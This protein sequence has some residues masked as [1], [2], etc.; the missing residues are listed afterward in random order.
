MP[1]F[2]KPSASLRNQDTESHEFEGGNTRLLT[3]AVTKAKCEA[4]DISILL[5]S[6]R[7]W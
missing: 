7:D 4:M 5:E 6:K 3:D 1:Q 2:E